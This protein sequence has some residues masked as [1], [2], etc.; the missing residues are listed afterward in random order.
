MPEKT[1][2]HYGGTSAPLVVNDLAIAGVSGGD[3]N[4]RGFLPLITPLPENWYGDSGM[5]RGPANRDRR[6]GAAM[7]S[8]ATEEV[9]GSPALTI[10]I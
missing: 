1:E 3:E 4:V 6:L 10:R 2:E 5:S 9:R 8:R 7:R